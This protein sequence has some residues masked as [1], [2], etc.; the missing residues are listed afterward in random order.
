MW[1]VC[2]YSFEDVAAKSFAE[3]VFGIVFV[4]SYYD[5]VVFVDWA[6]LALPGEGSTD[7]DG[8][9]GADAVSWV[10]SHYIYDY[11]L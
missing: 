8:V 6:G 11:K 7:S 3:F 2:F 10:V 4:F 5:F 9:V 1:V